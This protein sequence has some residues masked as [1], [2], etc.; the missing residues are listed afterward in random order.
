MDTQTA[1]QITL[2][3][4]E[5]LDACKSLYWD[6]WPSIRD[7]YV[8]K[9]K[10]HKRCNKTSSLLGSAIKMSEGQP[11]SYKMVLLGASVDEEPETQKPVPEY[12]DEDAV[13]L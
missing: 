10:E 4:K 11:A 12:K 7:E 8:V 9:L 1:M 2:K 5:C 6:R 3:V 13:E